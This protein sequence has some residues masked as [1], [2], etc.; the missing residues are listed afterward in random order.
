MHEF[1]DDKCKA[2][3][4]N[5]TE[6]MKKGYSKILIEEF[7]F[8]KE[9]HSGSFYP[10]IDMIL[11]VFGPGVVRTQSKWETILRSVGLTVS[12]VWHP[13]AEGPSIIEAEL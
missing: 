1:S 4:N 7:I 3:L 2:I 6:V 12:G 8:E 11:M 13:N 10:M 9:S 5:I